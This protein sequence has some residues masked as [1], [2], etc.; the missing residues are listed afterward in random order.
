ML[1]MLLSKCISCGFKG[2]GFEQTVRNLKV[3]SSDGTLINKNS[4]QGDVLLKCPKC[5]YLREG[6]YTFVTDKKL[7]DKLSEKDEEDFIKTRDEMFPNRSY[8]EKKIEVKE[9]EPKCVKCGEPKFELS[10]TADHQIMAVC[11]NCG[12]RH[13]LDAVDGNL[14]FWSPKMNRWRTSST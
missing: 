3:V 11:V 8:D 12:E 6:T 7:G 5:G 13:V 4:I 9:A 1:T 2:K 14:H 10:R